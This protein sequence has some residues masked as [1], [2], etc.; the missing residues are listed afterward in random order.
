MGMVLT[1]AC[2]CDRGNLGLAMGLHA[3]W[4]WGLTSL[5]SVFCLSYTDQVPKW[6]TGIADQ[7]LAGGVGIVMLLGVAGV[8]AMVYL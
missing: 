1:L 2:L 5:N 7:P 8:L 6:I 3:G 4:I